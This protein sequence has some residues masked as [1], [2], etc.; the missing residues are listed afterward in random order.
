MIERRYPI[1]DI[2]DLE[3]GV[4]PVPSAELGKGSTLQR[5]SFA[6]EG[7]TCRWVTTH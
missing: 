4:I 2:E 6:L 1:D 7:M 3:Y 5:T